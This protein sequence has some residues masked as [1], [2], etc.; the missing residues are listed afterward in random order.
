LT[1]NSLQLSGGQIAFGEP[2]VQDN[3]G[4]GPIDQRSWWIEMLANNSG[5][6]ISQG[7]DDFGYRFGGPALNGKSVSIRSVGPDTLS[8]RVPAVVSLEMRKDADGA[9]PYLIDTEGL[10]VFAASG[11]YADKAIRR[12]AALIRSLPDTPFATY[13]EKTRGMPATTE[14]ERLARQ[15]VGQDIFR[16]SLEDYWGGCCPI[17]GVSDRA[18]LRASH[19]K[20][21][22]DCET[23]E[24]RLD[25]YNGF[26]LTA[27]IDAA[28]D[29][30]LM[31]ID[32]D[33]AILFSPKLSEKARALLMNG[34]D[35]VRLADAHQSYL[36]E[37]RRRFLKVTG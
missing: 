37:H 13:C 1:Q 19:T 36:E 25:V 33:G 10:V 12:A 20:P 31:T 7:R 11:P 23:D 21:W 16:A 2:I 22:A 9:V 26:L 18:L 6:P 14:V 28:F 34:A 15:R 5:F 24:E 4:S 27:H 8:M 35:H 17:T 32:K 29:A 30:A 3:L